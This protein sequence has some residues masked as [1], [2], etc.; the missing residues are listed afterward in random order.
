MGFSQNNLKN[1]ELCCV[2]NSKKDRDLEI[3]ILKKSILH[4]NKKLVYKDFQPKP[5]YH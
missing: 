1:Q 3:K 2:M 5:I 4:F